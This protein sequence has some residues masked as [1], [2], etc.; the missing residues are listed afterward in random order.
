MPEAVNQAE[1]MTQFLPADGVFCSPAN[2][3]HG[4]EDSVATIRERLGF[5]KLIPIPS[6]L[7]R[8]ARDT[9]IKVDP[10]V[11]TCPNG[12]QKRYDPGF[13]VELDA[14]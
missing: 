3:M 9:D 2:R 8:L 12:C 6:G 14:I 1:R 10:R 4:S 11:Q 13:E 7:L 5:P